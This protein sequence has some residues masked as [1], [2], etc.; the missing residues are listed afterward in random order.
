MCL[1]WPC[2]VTG[3][4]R[5]SMATEPQVSHKPAWARLS[6]SLSICRGSL[7]SERQG[8]ASDACRCVLYV[9]SCPSTLNHDTRSMAARASRWR[10]TEPPSTG[11]VSL[12]IRVVNAGH[13]RG[14]R[15]IAFPEA[16]GKPF[17]AT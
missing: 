3:T 9:V 14:P 17:R 16:A 11:E 10:R 6:C 1:S 4:V 7:G 13:R 8:N 2:K 12:E 5:E 15:A